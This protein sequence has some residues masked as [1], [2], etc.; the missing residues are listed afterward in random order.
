MSATIAPIRRTDAFARQTRLG[1]GL[2]GAISGGWVALH[3][4]DVFL[5]PWRVALLLAPLLVALQ[6]WLSVGLFIVAH[7]AMHGSLALFRPSVNRA[8]GRLVLML[9]A[10]IWY[11]DLVERHFAHH[12]APGTEHDPDFAGDGRVAFWRWFGAFF[13]EYLTVG[14][15]L[16]IMGAAA[17]YLFVFGVRCRG[18]CSSGLCR[19]C[20]PPCSSSPSGPTCRIGARR[21][22][23]AT[24]IARA[25]TNIPGFCRC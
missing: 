9:Y 19:R 12:R 1:L 4:L 8:V 14:Q 15:L 20:C 7:D 17:L 22:L 25:R 23:S 18:S 16:R 5:L 2:A 13:A 21:R 24:T 10:G 6:C 3:V 11:D